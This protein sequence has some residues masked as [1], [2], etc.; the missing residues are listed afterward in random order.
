MIESDWI[1]VVVF[2][3][4]VTSFCIIAAIFIWNFRRDAIVKDVDKIENTP[5]N[6]TLEIWNIPDNATK[7]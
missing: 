7:Q 4:L 1:F 6:F 5:K 2:V 3:M